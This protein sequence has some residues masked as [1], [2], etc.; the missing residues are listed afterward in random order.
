M[1]SNPGGIN[2]EYAKE[3]GYNVIHE[4]GIPGKIAPLS[5]AKY[6]EQIVVKNIL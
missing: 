1:A 3:N 5:S 4:L 6:I 2:Y